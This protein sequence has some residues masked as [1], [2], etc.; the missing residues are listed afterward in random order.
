MS[1][2]KNVDIVETINPLDVDALNPP[3]ELQDNVV[4]EQVN[5][6]ENVVDEIKNDAVIVSK[7]SIDD[8]P[9][10]SKLPYK[11]VSSSTDVNLRAEPE[12]QIIRT[13]KR[14]SKVYVESEKDGWT[15]VYGYIK[16]V[17][18]NEP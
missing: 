3:I 11:Y 1:R 7:T 8:S 15:K 14:G 13:I 18:L 2:R 12:G 5:H 16:S 9:K 10:K 17:L 6:I 4:E